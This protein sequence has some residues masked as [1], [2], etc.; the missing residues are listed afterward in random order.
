MDRT[1]K[2][3]QGRMYC[4]CGNFCKNEYKLSQTKLIIEILELNRLLKMSL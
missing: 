2:I 1:Y 3:T 4:F